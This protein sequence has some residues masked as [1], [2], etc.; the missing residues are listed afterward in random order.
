MGLDPFPVR[1]S[2]RMHSSLLSRDKLHVCDRHMSL[3]VRA[4]RA[5][6]R[7][8]SETCL[9]GCNLPVFGRHRFHDVWSQPSE[10][11]LSLPQTGGHRVHDR[12]GVFML[13]TRKT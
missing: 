12:H 3:S 1:R 4:Q 5:S 9:L 10:I 8:S 13:I 6:I 2:A 11:L 7:S